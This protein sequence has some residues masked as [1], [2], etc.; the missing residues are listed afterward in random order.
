[1]LNG[2][3]RIKTRDPSV[4][5]NR[6]LQPSGIILVNNCNGQFTHKLSSHMCDTTRHDSMRHD[7]TEDQGT[8][9]F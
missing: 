6:R 9:I 1:M 4:D 5:G 7:R 2:I 8:M 3:I